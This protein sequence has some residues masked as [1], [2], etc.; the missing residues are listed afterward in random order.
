MGVLRYGQACEEYQIGLSVMLRARRTETD[1]VKSKILHDVISFY[2]SKAELCKNK[3]E[4]Q[5]L[6][7]NMAKIQEDSVL[8]NTMLDESN[9]NTEKKS[10]S[11]QNCCLQ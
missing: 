6:D 3:N 1:P 8:D 9:V 2:L 5:Q 4:A 10:T 7:I 11:Q